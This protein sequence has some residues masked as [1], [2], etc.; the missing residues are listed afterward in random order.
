VSRHRP[1]THPM[2]P[3]RSAAPLASQTTL[4]FLFFRMHW[5][6]LHSVTGELNLFG[7]CVRLPQD[8]TRLPLGPRRVFNRYRRELSSFDI[9]A[10]VG[11]WLSSALAPFIRL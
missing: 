8:R 5:L 9:C 2:S 11:F 4:P 7:V 1:L 3:R 10:S 6:P